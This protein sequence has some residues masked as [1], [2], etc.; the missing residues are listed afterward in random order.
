MEMGI[1]RAGITVLKYFLDVS[2][3]EQERRFLR[4]I[5]DPLRQWKLSPMD[6]ES[7]QRW[8]DY[9]EAIDTMIAATDTPVVPWYV[10]NS[11]DKRRARLNCISHL[12][13]KIPYDTVKTKPV[14][15]PP[16]EKRNRDQSK[17]V[18]F[19]NV[20]DNTY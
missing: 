7:Y 8:W 4:R 19:K 10:V 17:T 5:S 15:L 11:D 9:T 18:M 6:L 16:R 20:V 13:S 14:K 12:L 1:A 2:Q 3:E